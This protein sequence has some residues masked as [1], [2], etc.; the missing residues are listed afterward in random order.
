[1]GIYKREEV[2]YVQFFYQGKKYRW[3]ADTH[4]KKVAEEYLSDIKHSIRNREF[5]KKYLNIE[6][7]GAALLIVEA[8]DWYMCNYIQGKMK[9]KNVKGVKY[10][11]ENFVKITGN[12]KIMDYR[13]KDIEKYKLERLKTVTKNSIDR[14]LGTISGLFSRLT[15]YEMID[16]NPMANKIIYFHENNSRVRFASQVELKMIFDNIHELEFKMIVTIGLMTGIRLSDI[17]NLKLMNIDFNNRVISFRMSKVN[18]DHAI[19]MS[20]VLTE[21]IKKYIQ[22]YGIKDSLFTLDSPKVSNIWRGL[23]L[24]LGI[25]PHL[26]FRDLRRSFATLLYNQ[27]G[28]DIKLVSELLGHSKIDI[29]SEVYTKTQ[30]EKK[31]TA[32]DGM[33]IEF[34]K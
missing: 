27:D 33:N 13:L 8:C 31:R 25:K 23:I 19:P 4:L 9:E 18:K 21:I 15:R 16:Y 1:M 32:L 7:E 17:C 3:S 26:Q 24:S 2:Y 29:S 5:E 34:I 30:I 11:L 10:T 14:E 6:N 28:V 22:D 12:K 20:A